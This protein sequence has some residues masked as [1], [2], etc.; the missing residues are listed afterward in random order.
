MFLY[1]KARTSMSTQD[2]GTL[3]FNEWHNVILCPVLNTFSK[4]PNIVL[5]FVVAII[6]VI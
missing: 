6:P 3:S 2:V 5:D 1:S 4:M